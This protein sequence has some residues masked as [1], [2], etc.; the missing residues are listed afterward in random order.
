MTGRPVVGRSISTKFVLPKS[1]EDLEIIVVNSLFSIA[2]GLFWTDCSI[3]AS[4]SFIDGLLSS[5]V[6]IWKFDCSGKADRSFWAC[7]SLQV[8]LWISLL[9]VC[10]FF[11]DTLWMESVLFTLFREPETVFLSS[12]TSVLVM[13][14]IGIINSCGCLW[15]ILYNTSSGIIP[16]GN[17]QSKLIWNKLFVST[18]HGVCIKI[19]VIALHC[20]EHWP[21]VFANCL[22]IWGAIL[23][24]KNWFLMVIKFL[25]YQ[26]QVH[27]IL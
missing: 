8:M 4:C 16:L 23:S 6:C 11:Q 10:I 18:L 14:D 7:I 17:C 13:F 12:L 5:W 9:V 26:F 2:Q 22:R 19:H 25:P 27:P 1:A 15:S 20:K 24:A 3:S 21:L